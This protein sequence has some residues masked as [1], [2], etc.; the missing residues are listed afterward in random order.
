MAKLTP[1]K[2]R[3]MLWRRGIL[4]F[5]LDV[6]QQELY[7]V[8]KD[9]NPKTKIVV[10]NCAR[11]T[12]KSWALV[13]IAIEECLKNPK[14]L[15]KYCCPK[16]KDAK[17]IVQPLFR[18]ILEG[19][20]EDIKPEY[21]TN[22][23]AYIFPNGAKIQLSGLDGGRAESVRGGSAVLAIVDEAGAVL[24]TRS[25]SS[26]RD[27]GLT[28]VI[29]SILLPAVTRTKEINGKIILAST[30]PKKDTHPFVFFFRRAEINKAAV[31][32]TIHANPR[33]T[34]EMYET[35]AENMGG[36]KSVDFRREYLCEIISSEDSQVV[37]E[38]T[39]ELRDRII[40]QWERPAFFKSYVSMD[41]GAKDLTVVLFAYYDFKNGK[42]IIEDEL[43]MPGKF[44]TKSL[45]DSIKLK[46]FMLFTHPIS[47]EF[48]P[49]FKRVSDNNLIVIN[50]MYEL[51][52]L[53]F[54]PTK[55]DDKDAALNNMRIMLAADKIIINPRC[56]A[57]IRHLRDAT[58]AKNRKTYDRSADN[59][60]YDAVDAL[61]YLI[62]NIDFNSNPYPAGYGMPTGDNY[63][64]Y[65]KPKNSNYR[66]AVSRMM[67][68][69]P[70]K[71]RDETLITQILDT[72]KSIK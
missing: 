27:S 71:K 3:E 49:P 32:R 11:G 28:Y 7:R 55:K 46:E 22:E 58:W 30:P 48:Q 40:K 63:Y 44:T 68:L 52:Q 45:A 4:T 8:Y 42:V 66:E 10:W 59:G 2:A 56:E 67:N 65:G 37:P 18:D 31:T 53:L 39:Q 50:D 43:V 15:V 13:A 36:E 47:K 61:S 35:L 33:M 69:N 19:C 57:L 5:K 21:K 29:R 12:G 9:S 16:Q 62:R 41:L 25:T 34:K 14:A 1:E 70:S 64:Q 60:H 26:D 17:E 38:F 24:S 54:E 23:G 72:K 20:P 6:N 51:H